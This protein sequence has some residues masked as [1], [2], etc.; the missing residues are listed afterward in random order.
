MEYNSNHPTQRL[1]APRHIDTAG[2]TLIHLPYQ[3]PK[4]AEARFKRNQIKA[5]Q[6]FRV[7]AGN[8]I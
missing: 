6:S 8:N 7:R 4:A 5:A 1:L 2:F 3:D